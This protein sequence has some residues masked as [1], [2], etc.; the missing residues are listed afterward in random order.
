MTD[1]P[2]LREERALQAQGYAHIAGLDEAGRGAWAGPV[3]AAAV[4]LPLDRSDLAQALHGVRDSKQCTPTQRDVLF[5]RVQAAALAVGV[6]AVAAGRVDAVG[7]LP[8]TREA[9]AQA[10]SRLGVTP[11]AL[12][13]DA[14]RLPDLSLPQRPLIKGDARSLS[15]AA[16]S[17]VAKVTRDRMMVALD[18]RY[19]GYGFARHKGYGTREH[20]QALA[21]LG[22]SPV[23]RTSYAPLK[24]LA[25]QTDEAVKVLTYNVH[26][27]RDCDDCLNLGRVVD[28][29]AATGADVVGLNEVFHPL[30][31]DGRAHALLSSMAARL[32]MAFAFGPTAAYSD[33]GHVAGPYGNA[34]L[35][36]Y[37]PGNVRTVFLPQTE[38]HYRRAVLRAELAVGRETWAVYVTHLNHL[39]EAVRD[40][41]VAA[42]LEI[43]A[44]FDDRLH[45]LMGDFNA[46]APADFVD[47]P[48][49]LQRLEADVCGGEGA[50]DLL[51]LQAV[52]RL[53][54][55]GYA[56]AWAAAADGRDGATWPAPSP[57]VRVD[58][59]FVPPALQPRLSACRVPG[60]PLVCAAS[61]HRPVLAEFAGC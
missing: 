60:S 40:A 42:L 50:Q 10:V 12:L 20:K 4:V 17:I 19:S 24:K 37:P 35:S 1:W 21:W 25:G 58:Y 14:L 29:I 49:E 13:I 36:R 39:S 51:P 9:M 44:R 38:G 11:D 48:G 57:Q 52:P 28:V 30:A 45:L 3:V 16:A 53:L 32:G 22:P 2:D 56:D 33:W 34:L 61:D 18:G 31:A 46:L 7:I 54:D 15:I 27:W 43:V 8:A 59:L 55:A 26:H 23:H 5:G 6:G 47:R 41:E